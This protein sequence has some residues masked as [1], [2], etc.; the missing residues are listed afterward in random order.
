MGKANNIP[1]TASLKLGNVT[2]YL[3]I[4]AI[5]SWAIRESNFAKKGIKEAFTT[6]S[7]K[8]KQRDNIASKKNKKPE[9]SVLDSFLIFSFNH[10]IYLGAVLILG[11][12][13]YPL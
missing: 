12:K 4:T 1:F 2:S 6:Q 9:N 11:S 8:K 5:W 10:L 3:C 7:T 13:R